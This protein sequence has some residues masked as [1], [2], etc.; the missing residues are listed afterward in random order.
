[1]YD[2]LISQKETELSSSSFHFFIREVSIKEKTEV[3]NSEPRSGMAASRRYW[4]KK[5]W[6]WAQGKELFQLLGE[7]PLAPSSIYMHPAES[8]V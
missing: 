4:P 2:A 3:R 5:D 8:R 1:M 6:S 7:A